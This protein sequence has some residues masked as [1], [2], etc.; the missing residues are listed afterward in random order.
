MF[1]RLLH[2]RIRRFEA[3]LDQD[4]AYAHEL[5]DISGGAFRRSGREG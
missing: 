4:M 2:A 5:L 3:E 1:K